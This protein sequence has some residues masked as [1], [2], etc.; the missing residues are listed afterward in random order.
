MSNSTDPDA[1][2][3]PRSQRKRASY[4]IRVVFPHGVAWLRHG[5]ITGVGPIVRFRDKQTAEVNLE[6]IREGLEP[7]A[8]ASVVRVAESTTR[9]AAK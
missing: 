4:V 9:K 7:D 8:V 2:A 1:P 5:P 6:F 3:V